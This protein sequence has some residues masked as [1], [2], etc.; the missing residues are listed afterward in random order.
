MMS[1]SYGSHDKSIHTFFS[2]FSV[3]VDDGSEDGWSLGE[4]SNFQLEGLRI[5]F[6]GHLQAAG[7]V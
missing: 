5:E 1:L 3:C 4:G 6:L 7:K 2:L